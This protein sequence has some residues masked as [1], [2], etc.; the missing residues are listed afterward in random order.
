MRRA[1]FVSVV[2]WA[3]ALSLG[4]CP[5]PREV[6]PRDPQV[7][8]RACERGMRMCTPKNWLKCYADRYSCYRLGLWHESGYL[9]RVP[10]DLVKTRRIYGQLCDRAEVQACGDLCRKF[11]VARR[12]MDWH[13]MALSGQGTPR[14]V[15]GKPVALSRSISSYKERFTRACGRGDTVACIMLGLRYDPRRSMTSR[16]LGNCFD[17]KQRCFSR[18]CRAGAPLACA[19]LCHLGRRARCVNLAELVLGDYGMRKQ[20]FA[21]AARLLEEQCKAKHWPACRLLGEHCVR[22]LPL[23]RD[24]SRARKLFEMACFGGDD[25]ACQLQRRVPSQ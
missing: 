12:C 21:Q 5:K 17:D 16:I 18:A 19:V 3:V 1:I 11:K 6:Q 13:L 7:L 4:G 2:F 23:K 14:A 25:R 8:V 20:R 15:V 10:R 9:G 22:G 24:L